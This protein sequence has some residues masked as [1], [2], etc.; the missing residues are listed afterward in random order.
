MIFLTPTLPTVLC[1]IQSII[2]KTLGKPPETQFSCVS[3]VEI[4]ADKLSALSWRITNDDKTLSNND[5]TI[6]RHLHDLAALE[7]TIMMNQEQ[8][9]KAAKVSF[10]RD[11]QRITLEQPSTILYRALEKLHQDRDYQNDYERYVAAMS[12]ASILDQIDFTSA[13]QSMERIIAF[14]KKHIVF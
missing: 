1:N 11:S 10:A 7:S 13:S 3:P 2:S 8:F 4:A 9:L 5:R 14:T 6:I 12:Y